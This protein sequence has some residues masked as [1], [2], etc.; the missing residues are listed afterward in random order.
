ME[1]VENCFM[2]VVYWKYACQGIPMSSVIWENKATIYTCMHINHTS[3]RCVSYICKGVSRDVITSDQLIESFR[4]AILRGKLELL[5]Q[6]SV[7]H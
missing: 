4:S 7:P 1:I 5:F 2:P 3:A 6:S